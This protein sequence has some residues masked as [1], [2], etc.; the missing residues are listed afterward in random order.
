MSCILEKWIVQSQSFMKKVNNIDYHVCIICD[1]DIYILLNLK[2]LLWKRTI[3][4]GQM[5]P[6]F[7]TKLWVIVR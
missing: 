3:L 5:L 6:K 2:L 7:S 1:V 4:H